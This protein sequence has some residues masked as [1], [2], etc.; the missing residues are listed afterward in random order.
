LNRF[1]R[2]KELRMAAIAGVLVL[3]GSGGVLWLLLPRNGK[4]HRL[5][6]AP[7]LE[8]VIPLLLVTSIPVGLGLIAHGLN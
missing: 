4:M 8:I 7:Y 5:A 6:T 3:I 2:E 1:E